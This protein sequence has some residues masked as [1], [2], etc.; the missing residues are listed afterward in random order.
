MI[1]DPTIP[2]GGGTIRY[3]VPQNGMMTNRNLPMDL[4]KN[5]YEKP[6]QTLSRGTGVANHECVKMEQRLKTTAARCPIPRNGTINNR[7]WPKDVNKNQY[8]K[9]VQTPY[10]GAEVT[11]PD[12]ITFE[13][14][15][16]TT[17]ARC[18]IPQNGM[19]NNR[20]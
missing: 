13:Q 16:K 6:V 14:K 5:R 11:N 3:P 8:E 1:L 4:N 10:W 17:A 2:G 19:T 9:P 20:S 15:I 18:P 12:C 7:S